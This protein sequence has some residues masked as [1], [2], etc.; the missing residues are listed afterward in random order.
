MPYRGSLAAALA[1]LPQLPLEAALAHVTLK[2]RG[3][4]HSVAANLAIDG[5]NVHV[6]NM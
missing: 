4:D 1:L 3:A 6:S 5:L 2:L